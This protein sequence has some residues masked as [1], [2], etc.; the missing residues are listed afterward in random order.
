P[1]YNTMLSTKQEGAGESTGLDG[2]QRLYGYKPLGLDPKNPSAYVSVGVPSS[3]AFATID[4]NFTRNLI[5][6]GIILLVTM[7]VAWFGT[8]TLIVR[9]T[10]LLLEATRKLAGG[11]LRARTGLP[12]NH[13]EFGVLASGF[14]DMAGQLERQTYDLNHAR[15]QLQDRVNDLEQARV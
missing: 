8:N 2:V 3:E 15:D 14:D 12:H 7:L 10:N 11:D 13:S 6:L 1:I 5:G 9:R 4:Q